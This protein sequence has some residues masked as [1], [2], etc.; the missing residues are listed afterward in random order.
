MKTLILYTSS[1]GT[2]QKAA[3]YL[4]AK[5][6]ISPDVF[7]LKNN[8]EVDLKFYDKLIIGSSVHAGMTPGFLKKFL[9]KNMDIILQK[10]FALFLSCMYEGEIIEKQFQNAFPE[11]LRNASVY[12]A[13]SGG[14]FIFEKMNFIERMMV[15]KVA[16]VK[17][18]VTNIHYE[19][20]D[21]LFEAINIV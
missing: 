14:E 18:S 13:N 6:S 8:K 16:G 9:E 21:K 1:H 15:K 2:T 17:A 4:A 19:E 7:N 20:L 12:N 3:E 5:F 11:K 10:K